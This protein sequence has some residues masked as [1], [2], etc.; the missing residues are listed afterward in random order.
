MENAREQITKAL[1]EL[2]VDYKDEKLIICELGL[3]RYQVSIEDKYFGIFDI[4]RN[5]FVD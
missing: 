5:T 4:V 2:K 1:E 3:N